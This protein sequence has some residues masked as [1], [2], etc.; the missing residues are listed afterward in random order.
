M[1]ECGKKRLEVLE[2]PRDLALDRNAWKL[3]THVPE[4]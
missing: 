3:M 2:C 4:Y 1:G